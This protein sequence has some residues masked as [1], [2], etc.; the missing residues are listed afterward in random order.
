MVKNVF[1]GIGVSTEKNPVKAGKEAV[2]MAIKNAG[3]P[4]DFGIVFCD[5]GKYGKNDLSIKKLVTSA[6][7]MFKKSNPK[8]KWIGCTTAGE[9]S[10]FGL[11]FGSVTAMA[12]SSDYIKFGVGVGDK[13]SKRPVQAGK[14]ASKM[15]LNNLKI[16]KYVDPYIQFLVMKKKR[17]EELVKIKPYY[18]IALFPG[19]VKTYLARDD[20]IL[21]GIIDVTGVLPFIGA[22]TA[23]SGLFRQTYQFANG[24]VYKEAIVL[25]V[26]ISDLKVGYGIKHGLTATDKYALVTKAKGKIVKKLNRRPAADVYAELLGISTKELK[27]K[28]QVINLSNPFGTPDSLGE[29]WIKTPFK[30]L[31]DGSILFLVPIKERTMFYLMNA[32]KDKVINAAKIALNEA[33]ENIKPSRLAFTLIFDCGARPRCLG[34]DA[35]REYNVIKKTV[36]HAP[37]IGF[38][39][40]GEQGLIPAGSIGQHNQTLLCLTI[41]NEMITE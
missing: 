29:Y 34:K 10:N 13:V 36:G 17:P 2:G 20:K 18:V 9:I 33:M 25:G 7:K 27:E 22:S 37:F 32:E 4:P 21:E 26:I 15:A 16:D 31:E 1:A 12:I 23:D 40:Y 41:S 39:T 6:D 28:L 38:Y 30:I 19:S 24:K 35:I 8:I 5:G 11:G 3:K 14:K